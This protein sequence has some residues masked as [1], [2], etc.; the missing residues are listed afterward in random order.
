MLIREVKIRKY[1]NECE[2]DLRFK[3]KNT[4]YNRDLKSYKR[5]LN[6]YN[7]QYFI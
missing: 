3:Y 7:F 2:L 1:H 5:Q 6:H 4:D